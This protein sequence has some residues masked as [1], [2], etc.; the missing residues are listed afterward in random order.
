TASDGAI[1]LRTLDRGRYRLTLGP[2]VNGDDAVDTVQREEA[3]E[4]ARMTPV[5]LTLPPKTSL[6]LE[7]TQV[8]ALPDIRTRPDLAVCSRELRREEGALSGTVHNLGGGE[9]PAFTVALL[10][11]EGKTLATQKLGPLAAPL[12]LEPKRL[13]FRFEGAPVNCRVAVD[14][15]NEVPELYEE[16]NAASVP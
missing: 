2:D 1:R 15:A 3:L 8:E 7:L 5:P 10:D 16:N 11:A 4:I 12:D 9:A 14:P 13:A 6:V